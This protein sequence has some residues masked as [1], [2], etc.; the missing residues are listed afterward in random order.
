MGCFVGA[1]LCE[2]G[3]GYSLQQLS[4]LCEYHLAG[5]YRDDKLAILNGLSGPETERVE[6]KMIK[7]IK[8]Y[9]LKITIKANV[10]IVNFLDITLDL[11]NNTCVQEA[12]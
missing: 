11:C 3:S 10:D 5:L 9:G 4:Q 12:R 8:D 6:K 7:S 1:K 2:L